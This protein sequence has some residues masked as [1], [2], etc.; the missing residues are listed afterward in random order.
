[1]QGQ[2]LGDFPNLN[3]WYDAI[4]AWPAVQRG[5]AVMA[6]ILARREAADDRQGHLVAN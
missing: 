5:L 4:E 1:M 2:D 3:R 6:Y